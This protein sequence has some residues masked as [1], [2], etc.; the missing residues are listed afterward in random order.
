MNFYFFLFSTISF[1]QQKEIVECGSDDL[2]N[3]PFQSFNHSFPEIL[4]RGNYNIDLALH[5]IYGKYD[6][7]DITVSVT[8]NE[9]FANASFVVYDI[10]SKHWVMDEIINFTEPNQTIQITISNIVGPHYI[11]AYGPDENTI[12]TANVSNADGLV[13]EEWNSDDYILLQEATSTASVYFLFDTGDGD[14]SVGNI[15]E[16]ELTAAINRLNDNMQFSQLSFSIDTINRV[17]NNC[18]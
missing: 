16:N 17:H 9:Y 12:I 5:V 10:F 1:G 11:Q 18:L 14:T 4:P 3:I 2:T 8:V 6:Q 15:S 13:L 7:T